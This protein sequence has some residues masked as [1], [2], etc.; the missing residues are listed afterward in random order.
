M[1]LTRPATLLDTPELLLEPLLLPDD[2]LVLVVVNPVG[3]VFLVEVV[4]C[5]EDDAW[6]EVE[7]EV[8]VEV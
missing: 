5:V 8:G 6:V 7:V 4:L 3:E 1:T 2:D